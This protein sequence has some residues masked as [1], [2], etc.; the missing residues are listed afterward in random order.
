MDV[1][2]L[3][4][5]LLQQILFYCTSVTDVVH[6]AAACHRFHKAFVASQK[7]AILH[8]VAEAEFGPLEDAT[9]LVT[10][11]DS[12]PINCHRNVPFSLALLKQI[13]VVGRIA[14]RWEEIYPVMKWNHN[15]EDRRVLSNVERWRLRRAIYRIWLYNKAFHS[16]NFPRSSRNHPTVVRKRAELFR[17]WSLYAL[18]EIEDVRRIIRD[19]LQNHVCPSNFTIQREYHKRFP[20]NDQPLLFNIHI[21]YPPPSAPSPSQFQQYFHAVHQITPSNRSHNKYTAVPHA[22]IGAEGW[23]DEIPHYYVVEDMMKLDPSQV[24]WLRDNA[25]LKGQVERFVRGLGEWFENNGETLG[26]TLEWKVEQAGVY[27]EDFQ[28]ELEDESYGVA[29]DER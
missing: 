3:P 18:A 5:E 17:G 8:Q 24:L 10:H 26:E 6:M 19:V 23:G 22:E 2:H 4:I 13:I 25:P 15:S 11:N 28:H 16:R 9:Q 29:R 1:S 12:Q 27:L 14:T 21:N 7:L 20:D